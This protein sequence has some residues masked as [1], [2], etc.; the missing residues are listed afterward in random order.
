M[1]DEFL[2]GVHYFATQK[3]AERSNKRHAEKRSY[4]F[5][6]G[7]VPCIT[8]NMNRYYKNCV[9]QKRVCVIHSTSPT[10]RTYSHS[11]CS[12]ELL[13]SRPYCISIVSFTCWL[14]SSPKQ[15]ARMHPKLV[16]SRD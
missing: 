9:L 16:R 3:Q 6:M 13:K 11:P 1:V 8:K 7:Y 4:L 10:S 2:V 15:E 14:G 5:I 12:A